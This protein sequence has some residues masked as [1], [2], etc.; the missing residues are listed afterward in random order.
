M[1]E[2]T[3]VGGRYVLHAPIGDGAMGTVYRAKHARVGRDFAI[4]VLH[5]S[6]MKDPKVLKRFEREAELAGRLRHQNVVSVIDVGLT[7]N[8]LRYMAMELAPGTSLGHMLLDG[9]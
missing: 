2:G 6:L 5:R 7:Y 8:G 4:K 3:V 9:P 1:T